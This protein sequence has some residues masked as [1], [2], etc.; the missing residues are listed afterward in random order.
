MPTQGMQKK[1]PR[2][3]ATS[4]TAPCVLKITSF[5]VGTLVKSHAKIFRSKISVYMIY[6]VKVDGFK[7]NLEVKEYKFRIIDGQ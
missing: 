1:R 5:Q 4:D 3:D 2:W 6:L 7:L